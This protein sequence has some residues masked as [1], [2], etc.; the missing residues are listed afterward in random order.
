MA[1]SVDCGR[2]RQYVGQN[3]N[4]RRE[5]TRLIRRAAVEGAQRA[6]NPSTYACSW[7]PWTPH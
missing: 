3:K 5:E 4:E 2:Y 6:L 1:E 7:S